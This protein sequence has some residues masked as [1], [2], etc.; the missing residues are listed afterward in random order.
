MRALP[1]GGYHF[2]NLPAA[3][4][5]AVEQHFKKLAS[6]PGHAPMTMQK[7]REEIAAAVLFFA[8]APHFITGQILTV[9]GGIGL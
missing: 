6:K 1:P 3:G 2:L 4:F 7:V 8:T 5:D 9:D